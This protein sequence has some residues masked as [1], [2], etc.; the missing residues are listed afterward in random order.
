MRE[1]DDPEASFR[2]VLSMHP[3]GRIGTPEDVARVA[4]FLLSSDASFISGT[5][6]IVDGGRSAVIQDLHDW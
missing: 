5:T 4:R 2:R 1:S 6:M 3:L